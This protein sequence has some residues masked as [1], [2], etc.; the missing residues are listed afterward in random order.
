MRKRV[1]RDYPEKP[2]DEITIAIEQLSPETFEHQL[3]DLARLLEVCVAAGASVNF[4]VPFS[5]DD[6]RRFWAEKVRP[7]L[8]TGAR[9]VLVAMVEGRLA[10]SVQ[11]DCD[12]P[13]NQPHRAEVAKLLVDPEFRRR[14][15]GRALMVEIERHAQELGRTLITLDT[16]S[17]G[18]AAL[19]ESLGY[20]HVG[21]IPAYAR[22]P[23]ED[24]YDT[25]TIMYKQM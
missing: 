5:S 3:T 9:V 1:D 11:L 19:Y 15:I 13:P 10:G 2:M 14:G 20:Q 12:T 4:V 21:V 25:T 8:A 23:V 7:P 17:D 16:A 6:S 18:A 22:H 24:G